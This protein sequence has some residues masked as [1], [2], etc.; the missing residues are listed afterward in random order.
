[1]TRLGTSGQAGSDGQTVEPERRLV[2]PVNYATSTTYA[3]LTPL[4]AR[5]VLALLLLAVVFCV[6]VTLSPLASSNP[7]QYLPGPSD[8]ALYHAEIERI[9]AGEGYYSAAAAELTARG[10]PTRS[11]FNWRTPLPMWLLGKLPWFGLGKVLL[12]GLALALLLLAFESVARDEGNRLARPIA[13]ALLLTGPLLPIVLGD[14]FVLP[15]LWAGVLIALSVSA[16]G[17]NR[18]YWGVVFGL[19]AIFFRELALPYALLAA[20]IAW[21]HRRRGEL[22]A[23]SLGLAAWLVF[24]GLHWLQVRSLITPHA[25]AHREGWLQFGGAGFVISTIQMNAYLL[26]MPQWVTALYFTAAMFGF[27]GWCT[28]LG[29][30][31][32]LTTCLFVAAFAVVGQNFNQYWGSLIAPLLCFGVARSPESLLDLWRAAQANRAKQPSV[33]GRN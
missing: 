10:Y 28:P 1:V 31:I 14:L 33:V 3:R 18:P 13:C 6:A 11:V 5:S 26:L 23:W 30:R 22:L 15:V 2:A 32:G 29:T 7:Q 12:G 16:Y 8:V 24:F 9:H 25:L 27:A 4:Q 17:I 21:R 19:A 20:A